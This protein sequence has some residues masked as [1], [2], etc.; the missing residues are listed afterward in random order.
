MDC[1]C[2]FG[3]T[4][5]NKSGAASAALAVAGVQVQ[6]GLWLGPRRRIEADVA[7]DAGH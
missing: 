5:Y 6:Q 2:L 1:V 7:S 3:P 4:Q